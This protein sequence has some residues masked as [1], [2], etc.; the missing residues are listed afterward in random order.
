[1]DEYILFCG[2]YVSGKAMS[3]FLSTHFPI[4]CLFPSSL[5]LFGQWVRTHNTS[6]DGLIRLQFMFFFLRY[7]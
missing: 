4:L 2:Y 5:H 1:M 6:A 7:S 3:L